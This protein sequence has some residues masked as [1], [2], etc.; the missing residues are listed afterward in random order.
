MGSDDGLVISA[1]DVQA[2]F[3]QHGLP[4]W[5][6]PFFSLPT[7]K[8]KKLG[9][10][11]VDG[12]PVT[13][14]TRVTPQVAVAP[15]GWSWGLHLVQVAHMHLLSQRIPPQLFASDFSPCPLAERSNNAMVVLYVDNVIVVG[16]DKQTVAGLRVDALAALTSAGLPMHEELEGETKATVLGVHVDG[17]T[18]VVSL[19]GKRLS[20][21]RLVLRIVTS[22]GFSCTSRQMQV[23]MGHVTFACLLRREL[24]CIFSS[25]YSYI[26]AG[27]EEPVNLWPSVVREFTLFRSLLFFVQSDLRRGWGEKVLVSDACESGHASLKSVW[28][29]SDVA[30]IG[31][32]QERWRY[33]HTGHSNPRA[34]VSGM[35][36]DA[37][38]EELEQ[39]PS[40]REVPIPL[41]AEANWE[42][43]HCTRLYDYEAMHVKEARGFVRSVVCAV[44]EHDMWGKRLLHLGDNLSLTLAASKGRCRDWKLLMQLRTL[45]SV[46]VATNTLVVSR[47]IASEQ[48]VADAASRRFERHGVAALSE[49]WSTTAE[50]A[51][52]MPKVEKRDTTQA[53][54]ADPAAETS[55]CALSTTETRSTDPEADTTQT[56]S[57]DPEADTTHARSTDP[58]A[59]TTHLRAVD[60]C[61]KR[62]AECE[63]TRPLEGRTTASPTRTGGN[64]I[65]HSRRGKCKAQHFGELRTPLDQTTG[66]LAEK[67]SERVRDTLGRASARSVRHVVPEWEGRWKR[68]ENSGSP[69][70]HAKVCR[71]HNCASATPGAPR[72]QGLG[73]GSPKHY[74]T[75]VPR[76][77]VLCDCLPPST[78]TTRTDGIDV[79]AHG[80]RLSEAWRGS[81]AADV[82]VCESTGRSRLLQVDATPSSQ[83][84]QSVEQDTCTGRVDS[85]R[86]AVAQRCAHAVHQAQTQNELVG[87][88]PGRAQDCFRDSDRV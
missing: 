49:T 45:T 41:V 29:V 66:T 14:D 78:S 27:Y 47:W 79:A 51:S 2:A 55:V 54:S 12:K 88:Q 52:E 22:E 80:G 60:L 1:I 26:Q 5:I 3:Y 81:E 71:P 7:V 13:P 40:F 9:L 57:T 10:K 17:E 32:W 56:R 77:C 43:V 76:T 65:Q 18:G 15:M 85:I 63:S 61:A 23:L 25:V 44:Q 19:S 59:D 30:H 69:E 24:L 35:L 86:S 34:L 20:R 74:Q 36:G 58:E 31:R 11:E 16:R 46:M 42:E 8:A 6:C 68:T 75:A 82:A 4:T 67:E 39:N 50:G 37:W 87:L 83:D 84:A 62:R 28:S 38:P 53:R 72:T 21:M 48:N 70:I 33:K 64:H 73:A